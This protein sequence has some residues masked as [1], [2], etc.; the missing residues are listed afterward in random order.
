MKDIIEI[1]PIFSSKRGNFKWRVNDVVGYADSYAES[2][3]EVNKE[4]AKQKEL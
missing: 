4:I 2:A 1:K 3:K